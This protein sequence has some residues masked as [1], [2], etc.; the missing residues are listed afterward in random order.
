MDTPGA[1]IAVVKT[2]KERET[3]EIAFSKNGR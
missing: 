3:I 1:F 2:Q